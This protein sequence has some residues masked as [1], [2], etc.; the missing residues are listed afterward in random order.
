MASTS[1][2]LNKS[3]RMLVAPILRDAG[4]Q[5]VDARKGWSWR[6]DVIW[7]FEIRAVGS[8]FSGTGW[9]P[10]SV[11][12][13]LG[14]YF[15]FAPRQSE[16]KIDDKGR[17]RPKKY[18]CQMRNHLV[19]GVDQSK[20]VQHLGNPAERTRKDIW[21]V[22][23]SGE[24]VAEVARDIAKSLQNDG[25]PW[26]ARVSNLENALELVE[27]ERDCFRK[28]AKLVLLAGRLGDDER[29]RKYEALAEAAARRIGHS[30]DRN[31]WCG[32]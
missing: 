1:A 20:W 8:S 15:A 24:N 21:W 4:F 29:R 7:V 30:L 26:Y 19:C 6:N 13:W 10:G 31:T 5:Q 25:L 18:C 28:F 23:P 12:V 17:L 9:P 22:Q 27:S 32:V 2:Q 11:C 3:L 14:V 16:I